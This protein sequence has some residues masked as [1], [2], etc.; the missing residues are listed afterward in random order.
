MEECA[1]FGAKETSYG[2]KLYFGGKMFNCGKLLHR[3]VA[4]L[5]TPLLAV[6]F[7]GESAVSLLLAII[8]GVGALFSEERGELAKEFAVKGGKCLVLP[9]FVILVYPFLAGFG[10]D[11]TEKNNT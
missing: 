4:L 9:I 2:V 7:L 10:I 5:A 3:S 8:N 1:K 11:P 6:S